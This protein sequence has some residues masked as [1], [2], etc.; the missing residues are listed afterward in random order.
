M[1]QCPQLEFSGTVLLPHGAA[2]PLLTRTFPAAPA[3]RILNTHSQYAK[4]MWKKI[5]TDL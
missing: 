3:A 2:Q 5:S 1:Q 4:L